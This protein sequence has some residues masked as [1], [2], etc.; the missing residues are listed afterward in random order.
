MEQYFRVEVIRREVEVAAAGS[1][2]S[3]SPPGC[4]KE[5]SPCV[6]RQD[7]VDGLDQPVE[8]LLRITPHS[9]G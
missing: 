6:H 1:R 7:R 8:G 4:D 3:T 2:V 5:L 9:G